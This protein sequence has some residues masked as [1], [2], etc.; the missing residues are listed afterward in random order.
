MYYGYMRKRSK[1]TTNILL[2][3]HTI[4]ESILCANMGILSSYIHVPRETIYNWF[5]CGTIQVEYANYTI[6]K[7]NRYVNRL[8]E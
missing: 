1:H 8:G 7:I 6:I 5:R 3:D 2:I 4:N